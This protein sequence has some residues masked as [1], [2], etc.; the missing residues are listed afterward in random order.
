MIGGASGSTTI[1]IGGF[2]G[3]GSRNDV[4][5]LLSFAG[6]EGALEDRGHGLTS[7][8]IMDFPS[9]GLS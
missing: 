8:L 4:G 3:V 7:L 6:L 2:G 9:M 1:A 5:W